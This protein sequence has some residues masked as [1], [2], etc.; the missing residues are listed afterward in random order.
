MVDGQVR[1]TLKRTAKP[2]NVIHVQ[3]GDVGNDIEDESGAVTNDDTESVI[4]SEYANGESG[5][6]KRIG[7]VEVNPNEL[8]EFIASGGADTIS[9]RKR[10]TRS[11]AGTKRGTRRRKAQGDQN[12]EAVI[13][14]VHTWA[15]VLLKTPELQLDQ[16]EVKNLA[17]AYEEFCNYH[18]VPILTPKRMSEI[19]LIAVALTTYGTRMVAIRNRKREERAAKVVPINQQSNAQHNAVM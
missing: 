9:E 18:D 15:S 19:N 12:Y 13:A 17:G 8:G 16:T 14:M 1:R 5:S 6:V 2:A 4:N 7:V 3:S 11:D 10:R